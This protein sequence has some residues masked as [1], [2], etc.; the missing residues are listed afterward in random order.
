MFHVRIP[1]ITTAVV[2][3]IVSRKLSMSAGHYIAIRVH[4]RG[5]KIHATLE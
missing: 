5:V 2:H 4:E 3:H 1:A